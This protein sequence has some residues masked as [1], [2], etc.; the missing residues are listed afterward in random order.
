MSLNTTAEEKVPPFVE[1]LLPG[2][3]LWGHCS[4]EERG[5]RQPNSQHFEKKLH[6]GF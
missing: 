3:I 4:G 6:A 2:I 1:R 5:T